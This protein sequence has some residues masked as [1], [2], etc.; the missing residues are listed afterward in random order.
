MFFSRLPPCLVG[1]EACATSHHWALELAGPGHS[2]YIPP[3]YLEPYVRRGEN[4]ATDAAAICEAVSR[5]TIRFVPIKSD[6]HGLRR[7]L[8]AAEVEADENH[9]GSR[10]RRCPAVSRSRIRQQL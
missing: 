6:R 5:P 3:S 9:R 10:R 7:C 8:G 1:A 4:D 2:V